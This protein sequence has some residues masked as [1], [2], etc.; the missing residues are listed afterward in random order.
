MI[1]A[2]VRAGDCFGLISGPVPPMI[3]DIAGT[4]AVGSAASARG[5]VGSLVFSAVL[6]IASGAAVD[7]IV[8]HLKSAS[9]NNLPATPIITI[10]STGTNQKRML[11]IGRDN[12]TD[13]F[14]T[15]ALSCG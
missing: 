4:G 8:F 6:R 3:A 14:S 12:I 15:C 2:G 13:E 7:R 1:S 5:V 9:L 11:R 10:E